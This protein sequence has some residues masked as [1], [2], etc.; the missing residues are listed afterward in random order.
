MRTRSKCIRCIA[1][2]LSAVIFLSFS[3]CNSL[4]QYLWSPL[5]FPGS[6]WESEDG[7][8]TFHVDEKDTVVYETY[9]T[10]VDGSTIPYDEKAC[11]FGTIL[12]NGEAHA[13]YVEIGEGDTMLFVSMDIVELS[14]QAD[15][16]EASGDYVLLYLHV[17]YRNR[18]FSGE[19]IHTDLFP[20]QVLPIGTRLKFKCT[21][22]P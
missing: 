10:R 14:G 11:I 4:S 22:V 9:V 7:T 21:E 19:V 6:T 16:T 8:I 15:I 5:N 12:V 20:N 2:L 17:K 13:C 18:R 3:G 1:M